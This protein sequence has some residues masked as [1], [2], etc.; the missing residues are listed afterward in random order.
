MISL[1]MLKGNIILRLKSLDFCFISLLVPTFLN[2]HTLL[3]L[4]FR[5]LINIHFMKL[6]KIHELYLYKN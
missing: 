4:K 5:F 3:N 2:I 6:R 1:G